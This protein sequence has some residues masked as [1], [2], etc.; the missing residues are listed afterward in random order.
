VTRIRRIVLCA[1]VGAGMIAT[2]AG[3]DCKFFCQKPSPDIAHCYE[4]LVGNRGT[5]ATCTE[6]YMCWPSLADP[7]YCEA[8]CKGQECYLV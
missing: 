4:Y 8:S 6:E 1:V 7:V 3:A 2:P 5:M